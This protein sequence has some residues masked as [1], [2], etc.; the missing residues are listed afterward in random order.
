MTQ[1]RIPRFT[2]ELLAFRAAI[3]RGDPN[4]QSRLLTLQTFMDSWGSLSRPNHYVD[5][6]CN[7]RESARS[8]SGTADK[9]MR[10]FRTRQVTSMREIE[11]R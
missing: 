1:L 10:A 5:G 3:Q 9:T 4:A 6:F 7:R 2:A 8:I 11:M